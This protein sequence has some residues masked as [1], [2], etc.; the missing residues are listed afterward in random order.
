MKVPALNLSTKDLHIGPL[1]AEDAVEL[2][3]ITDAK[4]RQYIEFLPQNFGQA[5]AAA[6]IAAMDDRNIFHGV[7]RVADGALIGVIG[8]HA[9][10][11]MKAEIGYWFAA[12]VR[13][14]GLAFNAV[15]CLIHQLVAACPGVQIEADCAPH[16]VKSWSLLRRLSFTPMGMNG[17]RAGRRL[18]RYHAQA[19]YRIDVC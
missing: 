11:G 14:Q 8:V 12:E 16:N 5:E 17:K 13:G 10:S 6:L 1:Q 15:S 19:A 7:R 9:Q 18:L 4:A 2:A 3:V